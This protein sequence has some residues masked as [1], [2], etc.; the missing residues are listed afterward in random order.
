MAFSATFVANFD[1]WNKAVE[2]AKKN[3]RVFGQDVELVTKNTQ[4]QL[5][6]MTASFDGGKIIKDAELTVAAIDKIGGASKLTESEQ[7]RVNATVTEAIAKYEKLGQQAPEALQKLARETKQVEAGTRGLSGIIGTAAG[8]FAGFVSAQAIMSGVSTAVKAVAGAAIGMNSTL[9]TSTLQFTTLMGSASQARQHVQDLFEFAKKT[10]FETQ[11]IIEASRQLQVF[12][13]SALNTKQNLALIGDASAATSAPINELSTWVGRLYS[14]LESGKPFGEAAMRLQELG[15]MTPQARAE[16]E[17]MQA[18]GKSSTEIFAAFQGQL[19]AFTGAMEAQS[20]TWSGVV[21]SLSDTLNLTLAN[22]FRGLFESARDAMGNVLTILGDEGVE[23]ALNA[24]G[25]AILNA[26]GSDQRSQVAG[27]TSAFVSVGQSATLA[28]EGTVKG[29]ALVQTVV[30]GSAAALASAHAIALRLTASLPGASQDRKNNADFWDGFAKSLRDQTAAASAV[31]AGN[32]ELVKSLQYLR[33]ELDRAG[34]EAIAKAAEQ[35]ASFSTALKNAADNATA[36]APK[37]RAVG[38]GGAAPTTADVK[39]LQTE[40]DKLTGR[41][42]VK[43]AEDLAAQIKAIGGLANVTASQYDEV[44]K[45]FTAAILAA[46]DNTVPALWVQIAEKTRAADDALRAY[47]TGLDQISGAVRVDNFLPPPINLPR[48]T[49]GIPKGLGTAV[50]TPGVNQALAAPGATFMQNAFGSLQQFSSQMLSTVVG[51]FQGGGNVG[52]SIGGVLGG[53]IMQGVVKSFSSTFASGA[54]GKV[55]SGLLPGLGGILGGLAGGLFDKLFGPSQKQKAA[56]LRKEIAAQAGGLAELQKAADYA[57]VSLDRFLKAKTE[58]QVKRE[59]EA[60]QAAVK[61]TQ[62]RIKALTNDLETI[63]TSGT[64][65]SGDMMARILADG[66]NADVKA[67]VKAF[68][69]N[70]AQSAAEGLGAYITTRGGLATSLQE[71]QGLVAE[72]QRQRNAAIAAGDSAT[73]IARLDAELAKAKAS[74]AQLADQ[75]AAIPLSAQSAPAIGAGLAA[76]F[77]Q[78][79]QAGQS[80]Y[81][82]MVQLTPIIE[83]FQKQLTA[84]GLNG[85]EA[86]ETISRLASIV[87]DKVAGPALQ[88]TAGLG[89]ALVGLHNSGLLTQDM[90]KGLAGAIAETYAQLEAQGKGGVDAA[91]LMQPDLQRI[92]ELQQD[93]GYEVDENTQKLL[94]MASEAGLIGD[95][96]RPSADQLNRLMTRVA[97]SIDGLVTK[98]GEFLAALQRNVPTITIPTRYGDPGDYPGVDGGGGDGRRDAENSF[99]S[100]SGGL[101]NFDRRGEWALLHGREAVLTEAQYTA[102]QTAAQGRARRV[103]GGGVVINVG[104]ITVDRPILTDTFAVR[105]LARELEREIIGTAELTRRMPA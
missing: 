26:F 51:A 82:V 40:L 57:G 71:A 72:L 77:A 69:A 24:V 83:S 54:L 28:A 100:G 64:L 15:V 30:L 18:A 68:V 14:A 91:R 62:E 20:K 97:E 92:W 8:T 25:R 13:G 46:K 70:A 104:G 58:S 59:F 19:G 50:F 60:I 79:T 80:A 102:L 6:R 103:G 10:P 35:A 45:T 99:G 93:F 52:Q 11:P 66:G 1:S 67:A 87:A 44:H 101:R 96:F 4:A 38:T 16:L 43:A 39:K 42:A 48:V 34:K 81:Q 56:D 55:L 32:S 98:F 61:A 29:W 37:L 33:A 76:I 22:A 84:A 47:T 9:E 5:Q 53:G 95:K 41:A 78:Q 27:M 94:D 65:I 63:T 75:L 105:D 88:A 17:A 23:G 7:K 31:V 74:A 2:A 49:D 12:G 36:F 85:G 73:E 3:V 90:Y 21:S 89:K 86:F